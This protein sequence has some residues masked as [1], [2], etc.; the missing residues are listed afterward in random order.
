MEYRTLDP[1]RRRTIITQRLHQYE[2]QHFEATLNLA[3]AEEANLEP[4]TI[5]SLRNQLVVFET[6]IEHHRRELAA[7]LDPEQ[8]QTEIDRLDA[9][10]AQQRAELASVKAAQAD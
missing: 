5:G 6:A 4:Q 2:G 3:A 8:I 7:N 9:L 1:E 10:A